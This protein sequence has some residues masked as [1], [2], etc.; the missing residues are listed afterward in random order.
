MDFGLSWGNPYFFEP[1]FGNYLEDDDGN[2]E[3]RNLFY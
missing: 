1:T 3:V 2:S